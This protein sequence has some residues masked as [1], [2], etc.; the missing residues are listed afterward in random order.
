MR[1]YKAAYFNNSNYILLPK[2]A[3]FDRGTNDFTINVWVRNLGYSIGNFGIL[4]TMNTLGNNSSSFYLYNTSGVNY[5]I[6]YLTYNAGSTNFTTTAGNY[7][8]P[9][10][11]YMI[12]VTRTGSNIAFYLNNA[13]AGTSA[14]ATLNF[15]FSNSFNCCIGF[16]RSTLNN[17]F[18]GF[19]EELS[20]F[21]RALTTAEISYVYN[22]GNGRYADPTDVNANNPFHNGGLI[23]GYH[24]NGDCNDFSANALNGTFINGTL[25]SDGNIVNPNAIIPVAGKWYKIDYLIPS[26]LTNVYIRLAANQYPPIKCTYYQITQTFVDTVTGATYILPYIY[27][28]TL[29]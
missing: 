14:T 15:N 5:L 7:V 13:A 19:I 12:T 10:M 21:N 25:F 29:Q 26:D 6:V 1:Y 8:L 3:L 24:L 27:E 20:L 17:F 23:A 4:G 16:T 22:S 11:W 18:N 28:W 2:N 9:N